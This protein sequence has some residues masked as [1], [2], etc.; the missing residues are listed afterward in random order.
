ME[1]IDAHSHL[2][3][4]GEY[5]AH[6]LFPTFEDRVRTLREAGVSRA[7]ASRNE[8]V[9]DRSYEELWESNKR[10]AKAC[11]ASEG[12]YFPSALIQP[13]DDR[14]CELLRRCREELGMR[15]MG[16][17]FEDVLGHTWGTPRYYKLIEC[18]IDLRVVPLIHCRDAVVVDIGTR[19]PEGR[20]IIAHLRIDG[21]SEGRLEALAPYPNLCMDI[22]GSAVASAS[23]IREAIQGLGVERVL[24][25]S[26]MG[27]VDPVIAAMCV[28]RSGL[29]EEDQRK[30]FAENFKSLWEWTG[31]A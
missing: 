13:E 1:I 28:K 15:F 5:F 4:P 21:G 9:A 14:A 6:S 25:G 24:F 8:S 12:L 7:L 3:Y 2:Y 17:M 29:S 26:D 27:A 11:E 22:S 18:A 30:V 19:Y 16:E 31:G 20:F 23:L 10:I